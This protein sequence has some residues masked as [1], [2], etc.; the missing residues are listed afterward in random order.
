MCGFCEKLIK[1]DSDHKAS[2]VISEGCVFLDPYNQKWVVEDS[3]IGINH[4][5]DTKEPYAFIA[6]G[7]AYRFGHQEV[8]YGS[9]GVDVRYCPFCGEKLY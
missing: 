7:A 1:C 3:F 9:S 5:E 4:D 6:P 2:V 8:R